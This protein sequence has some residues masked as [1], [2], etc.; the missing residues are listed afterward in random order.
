MRQTG[1]GLTQIHTAGGPK[2]LLFLI[3]EIRPGWLKEIVSQDLHMCC[4]VS[5]DRPKL[6]PLTLRLLSNFP[7]LVEF[8]SIFASR[9]REFTVTWPGIYSQPEA[10][11]QIIFQLFLQRKL[12]RA[13]DSS[14]NGAAGSPDYISSNHSSQN[15]LLEPRCGIPVLSSDRSC[16]KVSHSKR[17]T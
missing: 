15:V 3:T 2:E 1:L 9:R 17:L 6:L 16:S 7:F 8:F 13:P 11:T 12:I 5:F 10:Q 14:K 4:L